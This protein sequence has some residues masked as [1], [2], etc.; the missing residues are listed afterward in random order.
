[1][2]CYTLNIIHVKIYLSKNIIKVT[3]TNK[4]YYSQTNNMLQNRITMTFTQIIIHC[5]QK[6]YQSVKMAN[7]HAGCR[8]IVVTS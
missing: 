5:C 4:K 7:G 3:M 6:I 2:R 1:M 8:V